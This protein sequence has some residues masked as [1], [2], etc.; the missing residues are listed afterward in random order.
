MF[1][2]FAASCGNTLSLVPFRVSAIFALRKE[3]CVRVQ[4][5]FVISSTWVAANLLNVADLTFST[6]LSLHVLTRHKTDVNK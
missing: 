1:S 2:I 5:H 4:R 3:N 6:C